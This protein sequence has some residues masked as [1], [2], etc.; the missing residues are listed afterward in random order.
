MRQPCRDQI[1]QPVQTRANILP[2]M[3]S[4]RSPPPICEH[5]KITARLRGLHHAERILLLRHLQIC[6]LITGDLQKHTGIWAALVSLAGAVQ[7][8]GPKPSTVA[9]CL[10]STIACESP[11]ACLH[12][13][14]TLECRQAIRNN[15]PREY[16][17]C[18]RESH[19]PESHEN[20]SSGL[21]RS[22]DQ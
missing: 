1:A 4:Q 15:R 14:G 7:K 8:R 20:P 13:A 9:T 22:P 21:P 2:Q 5:R 3:H 12:T 6:R 16:G 17:L 11:A 10:L 18:A 19:R